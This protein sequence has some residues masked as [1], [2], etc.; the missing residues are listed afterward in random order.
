MYGAVPS[1]RNLHSRERPYYRD[2]GL[3]GIPQKKRPLLHKEAGVYP[4]HLWIHTPTT[5]N[6]L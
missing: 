1:T 5:A 6:D 3:I 4:S 2:L